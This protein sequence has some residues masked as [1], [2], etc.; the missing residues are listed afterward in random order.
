MGT[1]KEKPLVWSRLKSMRCPK[2]N[3]ALTQDRDTGTFHCLQAKCDFK[4]SPQ[5]FDEVVKNLYS[6]NIQVG[7][8]R[9]NQEILN[10]L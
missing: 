2:C 1:V 10:S 6:K 7:A 8:N 4:M 9:E 5:K 3:G